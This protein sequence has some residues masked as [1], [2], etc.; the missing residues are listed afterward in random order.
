MLHTVS[1][2]ALLCCAFLLSSCFVRPYDNLNKQ[3]LDEEQLEIENTSAEMNLWQTNDLSIHYKMQDGGD[4]IGLSG[5]VKIHDSVTYSFP[6]ADFLI[7]YVYLLNRDG[8]STSRHIIRPRI[9]RFNSFFHES[10]FSK[11]IRKDPDTAFFAFGYWGNFID[12]ENVIRNGRL[13]SGGDE[14]E[15]YHSPFE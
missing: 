10:G 12:T 15:I 4:S 11:I 14:W 3:V 6:R 9:S 8:I 13:G 2:I 7:I 5:F 1:K